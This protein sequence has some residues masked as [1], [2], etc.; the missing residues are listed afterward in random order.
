MNDVYFLHKMEIQMIDLIAYLTIMIIIKPLEWM[1]R[2][3]K[4]AF[5]IMA[6]CIIILVQIA[7]RLIISVCEGIYRLIT[8]KRSKQKRKKLKYIHLNQPCDP[9][10]NTDWID[11]LA[12]FDAIFED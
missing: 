10:D 3:I 12:E 4:T 5:I 9:D 8:G 6:D 7:V 1:Y 11:E 2:I